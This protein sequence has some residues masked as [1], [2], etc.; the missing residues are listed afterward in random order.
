MGQVT[1]N[2]WRGD[3]TGGDLK[4]YRTEITEGMV[5]LDA[6]H[7]IQ[8]EQANDLAVRWNC[9]A[10]KC[11]SC[12]AEINGYPRLM[13]MTRMADMPKDKPVSIR[14]MK[15]FPVIRDLVTDVSV[16]YRVKKRIRKFSPRK[17]DAPDGT[18]RMAQVDI[19]RVQEFRKCIEC[20]LCQNVCHVLREHS[21]HEEFAG[22]RHMVYTAALEM[23]PLDTEDRREDLKNVAGI[24]YCNITK[25][26]TNVCPEH[27]TITDNA[28]IPLKER[29]ADRFYDPIAAF[30]RLFRKNKK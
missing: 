23:H 29:V 11:G 30:F 22:P 9:K 1:F 27:I 28:I 25:C 15:A 10:G 5:V 21:L 8:A 13:C 19:D 16:N 14:P 17:P 4:E 24:G 12:S 20:F 6:V 26:C 3:T 2:I 7:Q 18:W